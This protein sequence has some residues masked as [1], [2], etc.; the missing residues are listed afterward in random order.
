VGI[1]RAQDTLTMSLALTR[2]KWGKP[3]PPNPSRFLYEV[4]GKADNPNK[5]RK[6]G[7][8]GQPARR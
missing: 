3:R 5:Y 2:R 6:Q 7:R 1:T 4:T 8:R